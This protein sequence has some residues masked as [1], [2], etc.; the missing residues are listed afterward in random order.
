M[1]AKRMKDEEV[2]E[3]KYKV[4]R[5]KKH[6][7]LKVILVLLAIIVILAGVVLGYGYS[8]LAQIKHDD[9]FDVNQVEI[10]EGV[11]VAKGYRNI[12][13]LGVDSR[14]NEYTNTLSDSIMIVSI[15]QD[16]KNVRIASVYRDCYLKVGKKYDKITHAF[17][18]GGAESSLSAINTNLD[19]DIKEYVAINFDVVVDVVDA[20][21]GVEVELSSD[22][23][24]YINTYIKE[25]NN[26]TDHKGEKITKPGTYNL[27]GVQ[28]LAYSRIRYTAGGDYK[29]TERQREVLEKAFAKVK[30]MNLIQL[31]NLASTILDEVS[32]NISGTEIIGLLSQ[33]ASYNIEDAT[34][35]PFDGGIRGYQP[36]AVWYGAPVN[37]EKQV[38]LLHKFLFDEEEYEV[39]SS[40][41]K[42]SDDLIKKTGYK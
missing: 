35:W 34:G 15:N 11:E 41:K 29:R 33:V 31:N 12:L 22:E 6:T 2:D 20:V 38:K 1:S 26:V 10:N 25:I 5:K 32:T 13:L 30:K 14:E 23:V 21:G 4:R 19:L 17:A 42:I 16:T 7:F 27:N 28:A 40:V 39:S 8:K 9:D 24:K 18:Y 37:L 36:D 3:K